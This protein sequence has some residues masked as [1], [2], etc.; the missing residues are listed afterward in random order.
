MPL[1]HDMYKLVCDHT[2]KSSA[3]S[4]V[5]MKPCTIDKSNTEVTGQSE[6]LAS[7]DFD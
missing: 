7:Q 2:T 6:I 4:M 3:K 5:R 1:L